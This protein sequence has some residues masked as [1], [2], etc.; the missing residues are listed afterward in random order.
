M[1][2]P[3]WS[4]WVFWAYAFVWLPF[5]L[6]TVLYGTRSPWRSLPIGRA[7][8][9]L[10]ASLTAV[11][12]FVLFVMAVPV[13][14]AVTD[15]LRGLTLGSVGMAGWMLLREIHVLQQLRTVDEPCP[16]R[17]STDIP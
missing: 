10:L 1:N 9:T 7:L 5:A 13:P 3:F 12:T 11:L 15:V 14:V 6:A 4:N 16:R 17:R 8:M 2:G